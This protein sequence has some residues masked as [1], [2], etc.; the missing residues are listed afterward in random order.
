MA[1]FVVSR[2]IAIGIA[3]VV[4]EVETSGS[5]PSL[6]AHEGLHAAHGYLGLLSDVVSPH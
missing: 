4:H 3:S 6:D 2:K 5:D 1:V